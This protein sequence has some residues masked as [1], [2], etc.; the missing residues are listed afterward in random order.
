MR[1]MLL[2]AKREFLEQIRGKAFKI[3]T[4]GLPVLFAVIVF[5]GYGSALGGGG[6]NSRLVIASSNAALADAVRA[7]LLG[8]ASNANN[9]TVVAPATPQQRVALIDEVR[10]KTIDGFLAIATP[11]DG[12]P[13]AT[14]FSD[15]SG[16]FITISRLKEAVDKVAF[17]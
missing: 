8:G 14:Y 9:I 5:I 1:N 11:P 16:D 15:S 4:F 7:Q 3:T 13:V 12:P 17:K 6:A 2:V 10:A